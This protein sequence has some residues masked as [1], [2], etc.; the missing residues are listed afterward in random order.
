MIL[1][2]AS[3]LAT[4]ITLAVFEY[5]R[6]LRT[7]MTTCFV[8][9]SLALCEKGFVVKAGLMRSSGVTAILLSTGEGRAN[10]ATSGDKSK[11][12]RLLVLHLF[13][14]SR[15]LIII[16]LSLWLTDVH[17]FANESLLFSS[18]YSLLNGTWDLFLPL[19]RIL[20]YPAVLC[21]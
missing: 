19:H 1:T 14:L 6:T 9:L 10:K 2:L 5:I 7:Y 13:T 21:P 4:A 20:P 8:E 16:S 17:L 15:R 18:F 12:F 3:S 11:L